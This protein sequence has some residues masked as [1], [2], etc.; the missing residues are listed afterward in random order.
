M[1]KTLIID[2]SPIAYGNLFSATNYIKTNNFI[3]VSKDENKKYNLNEYKDIVIQKIVEEIAGLRNKFELSYDDEI[4]IATDT[5]TKEGYWRKDIW[6]GYKSKRKDQRDKSNIQWDT[7]F[8]LFQEILEKFDLCTNLKVI[9][10]PRTEGDD[11]IF[12]LSEYIKNEVIIYSSDHDFLQCV[13]DNCKFW[14]TTRTQGMEKSDFCYVT[15]EEKED[16]IQEHIISGD[17][18]DGFGHFKQYSRFSEEFLDKYPQYKNK[19]LELYPKRFKIQEMF[20]KK[21]GED[22]KAY[23]HPR[24][25]YKSFKKSKK[26]LKNVLKENKIFEMNYQMNKKLALPEYIPQEIKEQIINNYE[27]EHNNDSNCFDDFL[28]KNKLFELTSLSALL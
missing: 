26:E 16:I 8:V 17:D 3:T 6:E 19:E 21:Y 10:V 22:A 24:F 2:W 15:K 28:I 5:S 23:N 7:A 27:R 25:G 12:V 13:S 4:I 11:I 14:R 20:K 9:Q 18:G 1:K